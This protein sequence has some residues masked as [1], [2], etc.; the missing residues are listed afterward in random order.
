MCFRGKLISMCRM[1]NGKTRFL[2]LPLEL[3]QMLCDDH[4]FLIMGIWLSVTRMPT[5]FESMILVERSY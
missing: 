3:A 5:N 2:V 1:I 4:V